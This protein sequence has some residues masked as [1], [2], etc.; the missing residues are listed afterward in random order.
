LS[1]PGFGFQVFH[2]QRSGFAY[3]LFEFVSDFGFRISDFGFR[4]SDFSSTM[5]TSSAMQTR[6]H[7]VL[8]WCVGATMVLQAEENVFP[9]AEWE[10]VRP[11]V[12]QVDPAKLTDAVEFLKSKAGRDGVQELVVVRNGR[13]IWKGDNIDAVH[14]VWSCTKSFTS[15]VLGLLIEDGKCTLETRAASVHSALAAHYPKVSL[16]DFVTMTSGYRA[17]GDEPRGGYRHGPSDTPFQPA[18]SPL[19]TP[20]GSQFAYWDS[21]M[22]E[23]AFVLTCIAGESLETLFKRRIADPIGMNSQQWHWPEYTREKGIVVNGGAGNAD[24]HV[25]ISA[26][27]FA[28]LGHLFLNRGNWNGRQLIDVGWIRRATSIQVAATLPWAQPESQIDG[29]GGYGFNW[30]VNGVKTDGQRVWPG[31]PA[32]VFAAAGHNNNRCFVVPE[33]QMVIVRLGQDE[34]DRKVTDAHWGEFLRLLGEAAGKHLP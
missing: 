29:R 11:E 5:P 1:G 16:R 17:M 21:A 23:L 4:I 20:P 14:G 13:L 30:W 25:F 6:W 24:K 22:N 18:P 8:L 10:E 26:R 28:R 31:A 19:F 32:S 27:E 33:W 34:S 12:Q 2:G 7:I 9:G 3:G 15:T